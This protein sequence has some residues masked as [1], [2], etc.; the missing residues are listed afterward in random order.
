MPRNLPEL[1]KRTVLKARDDGLT[2][3]AAALTYYGLLSLFPALIALVAIVGVFADPQA[4]AHKLTEIV[5]RIG[6]S[7]GAQTFAGPIRSI[8][9]NHSAA[10]IL[11][12]VSLATAL[13]SASSYVG[14]FARVSNVIYEIEEGHRSGGS[15]RSRWRSPS[16]SSSSSPSWGRSCS[17]ARSSTPSQ[18]RWGSAIPRP[19]S[20]TSPSGR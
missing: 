6:P 4:T 16:G 15:A 14:A 8:T 5:T 2:D 10:G 12:V 19:R 13:Y 9:S 17:R 11:F 20:G 3:W 7:S 18:T 1:L